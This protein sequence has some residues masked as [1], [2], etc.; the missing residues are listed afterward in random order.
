M[1]GPDGRTGAA[2]SFLITGAALITAGEELT[3]GATAVAATGST[4]GTTAGGAG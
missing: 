4:L 1:A 2:G 3:A